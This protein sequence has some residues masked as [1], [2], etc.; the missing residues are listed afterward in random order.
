MRNTK[1]YWKMVTAIVMMIVLAL[2]VVA[3][4]SDSSGNNQDQNPGNQDQNSGIGSSSKQ[5]VEIG[6]INYGFV[7]SE[8]GSSI[9]P[10]NT[11]YLIEFNVG[12]TYFMVIDFSI[13]TV[14]ESDTTNE[15]DFKITFENVDKLQGWIDDA[16][17][18]KVTEIPVRDGEGNNAKEATLTFSVPREAEKTVA[19]RVV[20]RLEPKTKGHTPIKGVFEGENVEILGDGRD[21][22]TKNIV[23]RPVQIETPQLSIDKTT[24]VARWDHVE[25]AD[26]YKLVVD[27]VVIEEPIKEVD[28]IA[29]GTEL[30]WALSELGYTNG[31]SIQIV[32][33]SENTNYTQSNPSNADSVKL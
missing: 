7:Q 1:K 31:E 4:D 27:G 9:N 11:L 6:K 25:H 32:A 18:G 10:D 3:C 13:T 15:I 8:D 24:G 2:L 23:T 21:G 33:F 5:M 26:Y 17:T 20:I 12:E 30:T 29:A 22:L 19:R 16:D 14:E 28:N